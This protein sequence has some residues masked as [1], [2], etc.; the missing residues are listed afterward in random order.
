G[1][2]AETLSRSVFLHVPHELPRFVDIGRSRVTVSHDADVRPVNVARPRHQASASS[3]AARMYSSAR[4]SPADTLVRGLAKRVDA[5]STPVVALFA[6]ACS[7][8]RP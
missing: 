7:S 2:H 3:E 8:A 6:E 1:V 4:R 5:T